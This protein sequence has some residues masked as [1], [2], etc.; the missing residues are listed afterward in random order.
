MAGVPESFVS[1]PFLPPAAHAAAA[2]ATAASFA[3]SLPST[4]SASRRYL[5]PAVSSTESFGFEFAADF[6]GGPVARE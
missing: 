6:A 4:Q 2:A 1:V 5:M 3:P